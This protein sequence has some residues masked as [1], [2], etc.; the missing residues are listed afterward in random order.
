LCFWRKR[1]FGDFP[2]SKGFI[3]EHLKAEAIADATSTE[4]QRAKE[5][6]D[7]YF[8]LSA[9]AKVKFDIPLPDANAVEDEFLG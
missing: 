8:L 2:D 6:E 4:L 1:Y 7:T 9:I 3:K 5:L